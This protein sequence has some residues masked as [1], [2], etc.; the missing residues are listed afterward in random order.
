MSTGRHAGYATVISVGEDFVN[1]MLTAAA[2]LAP[3]PSFSLPSVV[4]I[5]GHTIGLE[6]TLTVV[7]PTVAFVANPGNLIGVTV[8]A[9]GS[10]RL[11]DNGSNLVEVDI[12]LTASV[13]VGLTVNVSAT[14]LALGID[15]SSVSVT[16]VDVAVEFGP[17]L[18]PIYQDAL[19]DGSLLVVLSNALQSITPSALTFTIPGASGTLSY[20]VLGVTAQVVVSDAIVIPL[21]GV[22]D[23]ALDVAGYT[24]GDPTLLVNLITTPGPSASAFIYDQYGNETFSAGLFRSHS[25]FGINLAATVN[26][27]FLVALINGPVNSLVAGITVSGVTINSLSVS[28][29]EVESVIGQSNLPTNWWGSLSASIDGSY[30][31][32]GF[33]FNASVTPVGIESPS[34]FYWDFT[35]VAYSY[36]SPLLAILDVLFPIVPVI[37]PLVLNSTIASLIANAIASLPTVG[38]ASQGT[39]PVPRVPGWN[40]AYSVAD[41]A[42]WDPEIDVYVAAEVTG[43][44]VLS[45]PPP[46]FQLAATPH[47]LTDPSPIPVTLTVSDAGLLDPLLGLRISWTAVRD[48]T[49]ATVL[50]QDTALSAA[51]LTIEIDRWNGDL[52]YNDTWTVSCEVYRPADALL[53][54]FGYFSQSVSAGVSDVVDRHHPYVHW[55]HVAWF[56]EPYG[57]PPLKSHHFWTR[58]RHSRIHRTDLLIRCGILEMVFSQTQSSPEYLDGIASHGSFADVERWRHGV[59]C[60]YCFF[61]GPTRTVWK[62]PTPPTPDFV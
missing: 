31:S 42:L 16:S 28:I 14:S 52:T 39:E 48:D 36:S 12:T 29:G 24:S 21:D 19:Q 59:L 10:V 32:I 53:P 3:A 61:G 9:S 38:F 62:P 57:P 7:P 25:G 37:G 11:T 6:G 47:A 46:V 20:T 26:A 17:P 30:S 5:G 55:D 40:I 2:T 60:D 56:H 13:Q 8:G 4:V 49:G 27:G 41:I 34:K 43:P 1:G 15:V 23:V 58:S 22:L 54:R 45:P 44:P 18:P 33:T 51:A 50:S 35:L